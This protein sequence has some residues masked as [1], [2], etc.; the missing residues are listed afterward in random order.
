MSGPKS[1]NYTLTP[2]QLR[3]IQK[4]L[5]E[6]RRIIEEQKRIQKEIKNIKKTIS[7]RNEAIENYSSSL[8]EIQN[9]SDLLAKWS[10]DKSIEKSID[11]IKNKIKQSQDLKKRSAAIVSLNELKEIN[12][13]HILIKEEIEKEIDLLNSNADNNANKLE[14]SLLSAINEGFLKNQSDNSSE[15]DAEELNRQKAEL[16]NEIKDAI[17]SC[18]NFFSPIINDLE[19][20]I[21]KTKKIDNIELLKSFEAIEVNPAIEKATDLYSYYVSNR[22]LYDSLL[23]KY[24]VLVERLHI[25]QVKAFSFSEEGIEELKEEIAVLEAE[26]LKAAEQA[27]ISDGINEI[28]SEMGYEVIGKRNVFKKSGVHFRNELFDYG[29]GNAVNVIYSDDGRITME[30]GKIGNCDRNPN[31]QEKSELFN[32]MKNFCSD[33]E[34]IEAR[35]KN[36]GIVSKHISLLP[37]NEEFAQIINVSNY[38]VYNA[39]ATESI[40]NDRKQEKKK[41]QQEM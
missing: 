12:E 21:E 40:R 35:L 23:T 33:F 38:D 22:E 9:N 20:L 27:Y 4:A 10:G 5:E 11:T 14:E 32:S 25:K 1:S 18:E 29:N 36:K 2:A 39:I 41:Y 37:P 31:V 7:N 26:E 17:N 16:I 24:E 30:L 19:T 15:N 28:M 13:K 34:N 3:A 6:Q 8:N